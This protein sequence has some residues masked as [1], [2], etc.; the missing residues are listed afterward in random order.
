MP[1]IAVV[2]AGWLAWRGLVDRGP[3]IS[4]IFDTA[5]GLTSGQT[6][7]KNKAV[8]LGTVDSIELTDDQR[9]VRVKVRMNASAAK[10]LTEHARFWV[11]RPRLN[12]ASITGLD[13]LL[14]GAYIA[15]DAGAAGG[16]PTTQ[17][18]GLESPPGVR[19]DQPGR[20]YMLVTQSL[21]S[22]GQGA[23]VFFRDVI[24]GEVLGY[25]MPPG[26]EGPILVQIFVRSPY[27]QYLHTDTRF[28]NVS[29]VQVG[30]G[31]GGLKVQLKSIQA[32]FSGGVAFG[33]TEHDH[34]TVGPVAP[35]DAVFLLFDSESDADIAGYRRHLGVATYVDS[36]VKGLSAGAQ[37][38]MFGLQVGNVTSVKLEVDPA[39]AR[40]R[41]RI[42]M[43]LQPERIEQ[44][45]TMSRDDLRGLMRA[46]VDNGMRASLDSVSLLTGE[47]MISLNFVRHPKPAMVDVEGDDLVIPSQPGGM[48]GIMDSLSVVAD[49]IAA[50]PLDKIG[51]HVN[52]LLA[53][54]DARINSPDV[55]QALHSLRDSMRNLADITNSA[56]PAA[57]KLPELEASLH[58]T[59]DSATTLLGT[60]GG[61][62]DFRHNLQE[63]VVELQGAARSIRFLTDLLN[64]HPSALI[65]GR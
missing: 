47:S 59:L 32:L 57:A 64:R 62:T 56:K 17:F 55:T 8:T 21:G 14:S 20:T 36:S 16:R 6:Q 43:E 7:V 34:P 29:G 33:G 3:E 52:D 44:L 61:D 48:S 40:S 65:M 30:F 39:S 63:M 27:D 2:I 19:S 31:A 11:V 46:M 38:T 5:D 49:K 37:V 60:Y 35:S 51:V 12:G 9:H 58:K 28:W 42:G 53:H 22:I 4:I 1:I 24:V 23:P 54:A 25:T 10:S 15:F 45:G 13:T 26:G 18:V 41:V 50:M